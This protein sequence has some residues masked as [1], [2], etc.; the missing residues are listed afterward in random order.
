MSKIK[1]T[2]IKEVRSDDSPATRGDIKE[3][4]GGA[5]TELALI[6]SN[7]FTKLERKID[8]RFDQVDKRFEAVDKRFDGI[9]KRIDAMEDK[10]E[11][12][13]EEVDDRF[14]DMDD[15][16]DEMEEHLENTDLKLDGVIFR[17]EG[18]RKGSKILQTA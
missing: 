18:G 6:T 1:I 2:K 11:K 13:F 5:F 3:I 14:D 12:K 8:D 7:A 16:F 15:R 9:D 17:C 10:F 4:V